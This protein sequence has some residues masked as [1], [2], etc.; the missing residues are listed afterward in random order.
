[1]L[2]RRTVLAGIGAVLFAAP[3]AAEAQ[4][5]DENAVA[6]VAAALGTNK[7]GIKAADLRT[8]TNPKGEGTFVYSPQT[9]FNGVERYILWLVIDGRAFPLNGATKG[10]VTPTLPWPREA[11]KT[12][13]SRTG[14]DPFAAQ[15]AL[16]IVF[17]VQ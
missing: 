1:M 6:I 3:L 2:G 13:W 14:L 11:P 7:L 17:G 15:E 4:R 8:L 16:H 10:T 9:R 5:R 12:L